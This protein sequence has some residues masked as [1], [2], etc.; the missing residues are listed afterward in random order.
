MMLC[1]RCGKNPA[2]VHVQTIINGVKTEYDLCDACAHEEGYISM[3]HPF[4]SGAGNFVSAFLEG[5]PWTGTVSKPEQC[6]V[7]GWSYDEFARTGFV[8]CQSCYEKFGKRMEGVLRRIHGATRHVGK[9][10][11]W[12]KPTGD[13]KLDALKAEL[14]EAIRKEEYE[15]AAVLRDQIKEL[16]KKSL[17]H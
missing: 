1:N 15:R 10:P 14:E 13:T 3:F 4:T 7:C 17:S 2:S 5:M 9:T 8:G 12:R 16:E 6:P 11:G